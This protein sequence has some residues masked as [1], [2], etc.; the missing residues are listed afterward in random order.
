[1]KKSK[2]EIL[3][4]LLL[5]L[6]AGIG[7]YIWIFE[8]CNAVAL[9]IYEIF[10]LL[11]FL[12]VPIIV[13]KGKCTFALGVLTEIVLMF[14]LYRNSFIVLFLYSILSHNFHAE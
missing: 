4:A 8:I 3:I 5:V 11:F 6:C 1:M 12:L 13:K 10:L 2:I 14:C 7:S 9:V